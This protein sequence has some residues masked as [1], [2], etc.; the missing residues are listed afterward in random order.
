V[1]RLLAIAT[2]A[3]LTGCAVGPNYRMPAPQPATTGAFIDPGTARVD[4]SAPTGAW[5]HLFNDPALDRL[6]DDAL[7]HNTDVR[8]AS[9][10]LRQA[11]A[12]LSETRG[13]RLPTTSPSASYTRQRIG[14]GSAASRGIV[15]DPGANTPSGFEFDFFNVGFDAS[16]EVDLFGRVSRS[17]E[18]ARADTAASAAAL[19]AARIAVAAETARSY[20][21]ACGYANQADV[22]RE[23]ARLQERTLTLTSRLREAGRGT[24]REF[25]QATVLAEQA[26]AQVPTFEAERRVALYALAALT[27]RPPAEVDSVAA[28][29]TVS[30][31][32][33]AAIPVGD[34]AALLARRP[35][36]RQA[37]RLLAADTARIGVA[38][39]A[40]YPSISL[41]GSASL[42]ATRIGDLGKASSFNFSLGPLISWSF[43]NLSVARAPAAGGGDR[44]RIAGTVRRHGARRTAR[45]RAGARALLR[46][47][48]AQ[49]R[50]QPCRR[51]GGERRRSRPPALHSGA[52][53][54]P[55][56]AGCRTGSRFHPRR[57]RQLE[58]GGK[59]GA[60]LAVQGARRRLGEHTGWRRHPVNAPGRRS[61]RT[62]PIHVLQSSPLPG[63]VR[64][65]TPYL[66]DAIGD[67][68]FP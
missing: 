63:S 43:P 38:T 20:A 28:A 64:P 54:F 33:T 6:I 12:I 21:Q 48:R 26:R 57:A 16:Y 23:T 66:E 8:I 55:A 15:V 68:L 67:R 7:N 27:G 32:V 44:Q 22:A 65:V 10:N 24:R 53:Q 25:D 13:A 42:G 5:W 49:C 31:K 61:D 56:A 45:G 34:G 46:G 58:R 2:S 50:A 35:D 1:K 9:A 37:E 59:R 36:V 52:R 19:D 40:L 14:A 4:V 39:A 62:L 51:R 11:R 3:L 29:C 18:A 17:I 30:P 60:G 47:A 41:G